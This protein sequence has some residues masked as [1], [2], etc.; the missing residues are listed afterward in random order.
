MYPIRDV[1]YEALAADPGGS[2]QLFALIVR[3]LSGLIHFR[4]QVEAHEQA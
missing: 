3:G 2:R 4:L 1:E